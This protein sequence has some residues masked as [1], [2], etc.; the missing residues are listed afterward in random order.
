[1]SGLVVKGID[2]PKG[3]FDC[4]FRH[5]CPERPEDISL[6]IDSRPDNCQAIEV[7]EEQPGVYYAHSD[8]SGLLVMTGAEVIE[9]LGYADIFYAAKLAREGKIQ[10]IGHNKYLTSSVEAFKCE[11][12][13]EDNELYM[14]AEEVVKFLGYADMQYAARLAREGKIVKL[15]TGKYLRSSVEAFASKSTDLQGRDYMTTVEVMEYLN[16]TSKQYPSM[17]AK[18]GRIKRLGWGKYCKAS[19]IAYGRGSE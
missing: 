16:V 7:V 13:G 4:P 19:V 15:D 6:Y 17:L 3:C 8:E 12:D 5:S 9:Y 2:M 10:R 1:M 11:R 18:R 14:T